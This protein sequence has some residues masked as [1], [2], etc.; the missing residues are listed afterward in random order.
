MKRFTIAICAV[1]ALVACN[2]DKP[3]VETKVAAATTTTPTPTPE[4]P[5]PDSVIEKNWMAY[6][7]PG[8]E[9]Q[10]MAEWNGKWDGEVTMWMKPDQPPTVSTMTAENK[11]IM[12]GRYQQSVNK[13]LFMG[14]PFEGI[15]TLA[16]DNAK[17][18]WISTWIDNMGTG[19]MT[20]EGTWDEATKTMNCKGKCVDPGTGKEKAIRETFTIVDKDHQLMQMYDTDPTGKEYKSMQIHY[21]RKK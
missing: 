11:M 4:A 17:K 2:D 19:V 7:T 5:L 21:T 1:V 15:S 9:H 18:T 3:A 8:K 10:M 16:Y 20:M 13:G 6:S 14:M 12:G